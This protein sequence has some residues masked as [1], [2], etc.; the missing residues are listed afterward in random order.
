V[1]HS[2]LKHSRL[3]CYQPLPCWIFLCSMLPAWQHTHDAHA[4]ETSVVR[5]A[6]HTEGFRE[7]LIGQL[8]ARCMTVC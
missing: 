2:R 8:L 3:V 5:G 1:S 7:L 4:G 6:A